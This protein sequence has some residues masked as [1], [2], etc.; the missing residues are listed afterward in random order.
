MAP[1]AEGDSQ[2]A[3]KYGVTDAALK[4]HLYRSPKRPSTKSGALA[5]LSV[6]LSG[7]AAKQSR[8]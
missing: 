4:Y 6:R 1:R 8:G 7:T 3:A 5:L 2:V